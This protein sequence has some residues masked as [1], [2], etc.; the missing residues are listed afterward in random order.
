MNPS[1]SQKLQIGLM[2]ILIGADQILNLWT[3]DTP[4]AWLARQ[5]LGLGV[6]ASLAG[7][8]FYFKLWNVF[9]AF[10]LFLLLGLYDFTPLGMYPIPSVNF[11]I[12]F[13]FLYLLIRYAF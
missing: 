5:N 2:L 9:P 8:S 6:Y 1:R 7:I 3:P 4:N 10:L 13:I 12:P 11:L